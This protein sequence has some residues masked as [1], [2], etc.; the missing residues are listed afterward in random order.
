MDDSGAR[1]PLRH[2][3]RGPR[4]LRRDVDEEI[5]FHLAMRA[6]ELERAGHTPAAAWE[7]AVRRFGEVERTRMVCWESDQ[8][9]ERTMERREY[10]VDFVQDFGHGLRQLLR[11]PGFALIAIATLAVG[12]GANAAIFSAADHVLL[13]PLPYDDIDRI[14]TLWERDLEQVES[15]REISPGNFLEWQERASAF[16][17]MALAEPWGFDLTGDGPPEPVQ[18]WAVTEGFVEVLGVQPALG[19]GFLPEEHLADAGT[20]VLISHQLWQTEFGGDPGVVGRTIELDW[21]PAT[22]VG[23]LPRG[24]EHPNPDRHMWTPKQFQSWERDDRSAGYMYGVARLAPGVTVAQASADMSR[25]AAQLGAEYPATNATT[26]TAV[27]PLADQVLGEVRTPVLVLLGAVGLLLLIA[28]ANVASLLLARAQERSQELGVRAALGAG[29]FRLMRQLSAESLVLALL[30]GTAGLALAWAGTRGIALLAPAGLPR[31]DQIAMDGRVL[32]FGAA[33]TLFTAFLFGIAPAL[34]F[35]RPDVLGALRAGGRGSVGGDR[36]RQRLRSTLVVTEVALALMLLIGAGLLMRS[37]V[38]LLRNDPGFETERLATVQVFLYDRVP[39]A[40]AR[41][42]RVQELEARFAAL[43]G[44]D[45]VAYVSALPFHPTQVDPAATLDIEGRP[46]AA[47]GQAPR[48]NT[49]IASPGYF[50]VV[51]IP[52]VAGRAFTAYDRGDTPLVAVINETAA[53]RWFASEDP[54]GQRVTIGVMGPDRTREIVGV[55]GDVLPFSLESTPR[56]ELFIP[57]L[58]SGTAGLTFIARTRGEPVPVVA[59][60]R[61]AVWDVDPQQSIYHAETVEA[62]VG[63]T[64]VERRFHLALLGIFSLVALV[65]SAI[66]VY[67]LISYTTRQRGHEIGVRLALGARPRDVTGMVVR[68]GL[69]LGLAGVAVGLLGAAGLT[70]F[71]AGMLY[72]VEPFDA[73]TFAQIALLMLSIAVVAA[74]LPGRRAAAS[75][76]AAALRQG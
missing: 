74:W 15:R 44:V 37:F 28:C 70:R 43:P 68:Q 26:G 42:Q 2:V 50:D 34:R 52:V 30:G 13:R 31:A 24:L 53:R 61:E 57:Y 3:R 41:I 64:L 63:E 73:L 35:S 27:I 49:N 14:V 39:T 38:T 60:M 56:A 22:V 9:R 19:R 12:I 69:T 17:A 76:P 67:G 20:V 32:G 72:G 71:L 33:V 11:R 62:L 59:A 40:A 75:D 16:S 48:I 65:L 21:R 23:V 5:E 8:R 6:A 25:V 51:G 36:A 54:I 46:V 55:V 58:Q 10:V 45:A 18:A 7:E 29:R 4:R 66:G 1:D 47:G